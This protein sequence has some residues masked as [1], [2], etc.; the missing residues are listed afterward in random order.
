M[1]L[2]RSVKGQA[3]ECGVCTQ[4]I[5]RFWR[6]LKQES[7]NMIR[8]SRAMGRWTGSGQRQAKAFQRPLQCCRKKT[9]IL[10]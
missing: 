6:F 3:K 4:V 1:S 9:K 2:A 10:R 8:L 5:G 7:N